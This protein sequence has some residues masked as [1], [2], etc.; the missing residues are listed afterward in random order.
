MKKILSKIF[1]LV[2]TILLLLIQSSYIYAS[3]NKLPQKT[4]ITK[5]TVDNGKAI[6]QWKKVKNVDGYSIYMSKSKNGKYT[7]IKNIYGNKKTKYTKKGLNASKEYYFKIKTFV[8]LK[9]K[10]LY[11]E[12][13]NKKSGGGLIASKMLTSSSNSSNRNIN[14][15]IVSNRING[16]IL[17]PGQKFKWSKVVGILS[18]A[19]G[20]RKA[21]AYVNGNNVLSVGGG[22]CQVSTNL[23]QCAKETKMK[24]IE[25]HEHG[26]AVTYIES[27]EDATV[28]YGLRD[29]IFKN[30]KPY[31]IKIVAGAYKNS[32]ICQF[33]KIGDII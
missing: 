33:Y 27:G 29:F 7:K 14:L 24:I 13:S 1:V 9:N 6:I 30:N 21:I 20:Y 2:I 16:I 18:E 17:K 3:V 19:Q 22:V 12:S 10:K 32:T 23:Y 31:A 5:V 15:A 28:T 8:I 4:K 26:K 25:R 11:S